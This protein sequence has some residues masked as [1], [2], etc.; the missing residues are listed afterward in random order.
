MTSPTARCAVA[1]SCREIR[2]SGAVS[3]MPIRASAAANATTRG[4]WHGHC[5][6]PERLMRCDRYAAIE[7]YAAIGDG[8]TVALVSREGAI[9][10]LCLPNIDSP[11]VFAAI[12]DRDRGGTF[13]LQPSIPFESSRRYVADTN[14]LETTFTTSRGSVRVTDALLLPD[15]HLEP[16]RELARAIDGVSGTVPLGCRFEPRFNYGAA[17]PQWTSRHGVPVAAWEAEALALSMWN[18]G[19][20]QIA[21]DALTSQFEVREGERAMITMSTAYAEPLILPSRDGVELRLRRTIDF[22]RDWVSAHTYDGRWSDM[23]HRSALA[24]KLMIFAPSGA[25][26]AAPTT[27]LPEDVGGQ[28]NWDYRFCWIRDSNFAIDALLQLGCYDEAHSLFWWF[29]HAT[30]LTEPKLHVLYRLDGGL[31]RGEY[32]LPLT[33]YKDSRPVRVGN[34][35]VEQTQLD[36]YGALFETAWLYSEGH[37]TIDR[38]T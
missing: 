27:S 19:A 12:L 17:A 32:D 3:R 28:R 33:G 21:G 36:I 37:H 20:P 11:S 7:D 9:D 5:I 24:L 1:A 10:W 8:R 38:D 22:W 26:A 16:M 29:M 15:D 2:M 31:G 14:V 34:S 4:L 25:S 23:V 13:V 18:A 30:A 35:A 6:E